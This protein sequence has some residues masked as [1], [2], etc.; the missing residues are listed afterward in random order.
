MLD[1]SEDRVITRLPNLACVALIASLLAGCG[2]SRP[3]LVPIEGAVTLDGKPLE[4]A[5]VS[6][7]P[8]ADA[9]ANEKTTYRRPSNGL[10]DAQGKFTLGTY[11]DGDGIPEGEYLVGI[12][13]REVAGGKLPEN[14]NDETPEAFTVKYLWITPR[15]YANPAD[16]GLTANVTSSGLEPEVFALD[17]GGGPPEVEITG[18]GARSANDP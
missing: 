14:Y 11:A 2:D 6:F 10:T 1:T 7:Q 18:P 3:D 4:G 9:E 17:S 13:K 15:G 16:S 8:V 5:I 12:Y